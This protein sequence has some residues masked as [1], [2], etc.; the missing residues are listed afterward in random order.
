MEFR[1]L[2]SDLCNHLGPSGIMW[3]HLCL[4][5]SEIILP[6]IIWQHP[7]ASGILW[8]HLW[9]IWDHLGLVSSEII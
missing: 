4:E 3:Q 2:I 9:L 1:L 8:D 6:E 7:G 5:T